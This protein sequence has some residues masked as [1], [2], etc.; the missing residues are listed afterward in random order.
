[1]SYRVKVQLVQDEPS[2]YIVDSHTEFYDTGKEAL[3]AFLSVVEELKVPGLDSPIPTMT[4]LQKLDPIR[5][6]LP[7]QKYK[8]H[9]C[10]GVLGQTDY[11][12]EAD[13]GEKL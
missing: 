1:M 9:T 2:G 5:P 3:T 13:C 10:Y 7:W 4:Q 8:E 11:C 6:P 12:A